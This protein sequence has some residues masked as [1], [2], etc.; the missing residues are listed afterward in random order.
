MYSKTLSTQNKLLKFIFCFKKYS[1]SDLTIKRWV[2]FPITMLHNQI[3]TDSE[4]ITQFIPPNAACFTDVCGC[5]RRT[6]LEIYTVF[7]KRSKVSVYYSS[8]TGVYVFAHKNTGRILLNVY[9]HQYYYGLQ[10]Q[11][12]RNTP[13]T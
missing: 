3:F 5:V 12:K 8:N 6:L 10:T 1:L 7:C 2:F 4:K 9:L 11:T 13:K